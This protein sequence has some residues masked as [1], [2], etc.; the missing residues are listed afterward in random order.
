MMTS[1]IH[2]IWISIHPSTQPGLATAANMDGKTYYYLHT[3]AR[4]RAHPVRAPQSVG[5]HMQASKHRTDQ[6]LTCTEDSGNGDPRDQD[7]ILRRTRS[8]V[9]TQ[10]QNASSG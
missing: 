9:T 4:E 2:G 10:R 3:Y 5:T 8:A 7:E 1:Q 6:A